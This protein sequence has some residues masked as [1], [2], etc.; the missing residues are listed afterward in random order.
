MS[1]YYTDPQVRPYMELNKRFSQQHISSVIHQPNFSVTINLYSVSS[2]FSC[3]RGL[4]LVALRW[5]G[6]GGPVSDSAAH[7]GRPGLPAKEGGPGRRRCGLLHPHHWLSA[8]GHQAQQARC[9][10]TAA[11]QASPPQQ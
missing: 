2:H 1:C 5:H 8:H 10:G 4:G 3:D 11:A 9:V 7:R 6:G